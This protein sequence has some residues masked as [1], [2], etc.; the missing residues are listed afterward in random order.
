MPCRDEFA[1]TQTQNL[2]IEDLKNKLNEVTQNLCYLCGELKYNNEL[3]E[4]ANE[5]IINWFEKHTEDDKKR[6]ETNIK[7]Y[8]KKYIEKDNS[9][10]EEIF[11][12]IDEIGNEISYYFIDTAMKEHPVSN[13]HIDWFGNLVMKELLEVKSEILK[14]MND[15]KTKQEIL[16]K[17]TKEE[18]LILGL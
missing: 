14:K 11:R 15:E 4:Y 3:E 10:I 18:K 1:A 17:L 7:Q 16:N 2:C 13:Y 9:V 12:D 8:I 5:R 6:V